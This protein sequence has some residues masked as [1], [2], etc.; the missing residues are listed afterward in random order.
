MHP[1]IEVERGQRRDIQPNMRVIS[2]TAGGRILRVPKV[3]TTRPSKA[4][5]R[6]AVFSILT[7][8]DLRWNRVLDLYA[9]SGALGIEALSRG[10][11][12]V[13]FVEQNRRCC[14]V[15]RRNL[16][17][18]HL[19]QRAGIYCMSAQKAL[20]ILKGEYDIILLDPPYTDTGIGETV[21][22]L[23]E[24][25][26][27]PDGCI[28]VEHS[29]RMPL[30]DYYGVLERVKSRRHGDNCLSFYQRGTRA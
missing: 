28:V 21:N 4:L 11:Q 2:G 10:A 7:A 23:G 25:C 8:M 16:E 13:D 27:M 14:Q 3:I 22:R 9:G 26:L 18:F 12:W 20:S 5:V 24:S 17:E 30:A 15:I 19:D 1:G 6:G 29:R